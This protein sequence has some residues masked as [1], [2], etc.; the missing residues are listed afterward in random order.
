MRAEGEAIYPT[1]DARL[2]R[3]ARASAVRAISEHLR[4]YARSKGGRFLLSGSTARGE[5]RFDSD[6]DLLLD[7]PAHIEADAAVRGTGRNA[8]SGARMSDARGSR[9]QH[10]HDCSA[11]LLARATTDF[12]RLTKSPGGLGGRQQD[13]LANI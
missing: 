12:A 8:G 13:M 1:T 2:D 10:S 6:I 4:Q 3:F 9:F 11:I 5:T 7:F